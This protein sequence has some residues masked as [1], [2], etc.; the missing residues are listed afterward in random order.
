MDSCT[1]SWVGGGVPHASL[2][3]C[4]ASPNAGGLC[5]QRLPNYMAMCCNVVCAVATGSFRAGPRVPVFSA[6][7]V[8]QLPIEASYVVRA[9]A[10]AHGILCCC[11]CGCWCQARFSACFARQN[12]LNAHCAL[13][14]VFDGSEGLSAVCAPVV[15]YMLCAFA[16]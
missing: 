8:R 5:C 14:Q 16:L 1:A 3:D 13:I 2:N 6:A 7:Q 10:A 12:A 4:L 9:I 15:L 11:C